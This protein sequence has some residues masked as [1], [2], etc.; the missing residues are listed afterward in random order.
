MS[1]AISPATN[2]TVKRRALLGVM[3][4]CT[5][6]SVFASGVL[7]IGTKRQSPGHGVCVAQQDDGNADARGVLLG[8]Q[9]SSVDVISA[10]VAYKF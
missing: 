9:E 5:S 1:Q 8:E 6:S 7:V 3:L 2:A 10:Q 4:C